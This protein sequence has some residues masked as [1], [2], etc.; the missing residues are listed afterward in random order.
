MQKLIVSILTLLV[1]GGGAYWYF[2]TPSAT[3]ETDTVEMDSNSSSVAENNKETGPAAEVKEKYEPKFEKLETNA[4]EQI[5][6]LAQQAYKEYKQKKANGE[7]VSLLSLYAKYKSK[8]DELEQEMDKE[9]QKV[10]DNLVQ[11]LEAK[12]LDKDKA[13]EYKQ[14]YEQAKEERK[15]ALM[16]KA[17]DEM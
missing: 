9:F 8:G 13:K 10:Y 1:I 3:P 17:M 16:K 4:N 7:D 15:D 2:G 5:N 11:D 12:G 6:E 14:Q